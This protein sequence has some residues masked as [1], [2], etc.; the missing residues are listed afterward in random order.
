[1]KNSILLTAA[2]AS[3][4]VFALAQPA[5]AADFSGGSLTA[6]GN[7][8]SIQL[9][10]VSL[11]QF[12]GDY[13]WDGTL[14]R[15]Y[16]SDDSTNT[17]VACADPGDLV[18][19]SDGSDD[20]ILTCDA[21]EM[22]NGS[23]VLTVVPEFRFY[24]AIPVVRERLII[25]NN[26]GSAIEGQ[27]LQF[28]F[29]NYQDDGTNLAWSSCC[30]VIEDWTAGVPNGGFVTDATD[31][32]WVVDDRT[33]MNDTNVVKYAVA[34]ADSVSLPVN[35][36]VRNWVSGGQGGGNDDSNTYF[37]IPSIA[38]GETVEYLVFAQIF[39]VDDS[40][41][42]LPLNGWEAGT[43]D[44]IYAAAADTA[45]A[46]DDVIFAGVDDTSLVLNWVPGSGTED[47]SGGS[48]LASTGFDTAPLG[49][50][51]LFA[52]AGGVALIVRRRAVK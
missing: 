17:N 6:N 20:Q 33:D 35:D 36:V 10:N 14:V 13:V 26:T 16:G 27:V 8:W 31:L 41:E 39:V 9:N 44:A 38:A 30:G 43:R 49:T 34:G 23:G 15:F 4:A 47:T 25:T 22:D 11:T 7:S 48:D 21:M 52:L 1:M 5:V 46:D 3:A 12:G 29:N 50:F 42:D 32:S 37:E 28:N 51:A 24:A 40:T 2:T 19:A 18:T 45:L